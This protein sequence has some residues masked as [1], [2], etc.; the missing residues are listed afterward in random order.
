MHLLFFNAMPNYQKLKWIS[1]IW[2]YLLHSPSLFFSVYFHSINLVD[3]CKKKQRDNIRFFHSLFSLW[4]L[5]HSNWSTIRKYDCQFYDNVF[6]LIWFRMIDRNKT[7]YVEDSLCELI[8][9]IKDCMLFYGCVMRKKRR[10]YF[11]F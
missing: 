11:S 9:A 4:L 1:I 8:N 7:I 5:S 3:R 2:L 6:I 10:M